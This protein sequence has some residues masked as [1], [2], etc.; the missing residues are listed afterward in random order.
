MA[1]KP[2]APVTATAPQVEEPVAT[3]LG[4]DD[5]TDLVG[6]GQPFPSTTDDAGGEV[7]G[8]PAGTDPATTPDP[9]PLDWGEGV[10]VPSRLQGKTAGQIVKEFTSMQE[11]YGRQGTELGEARNLLREAVQLTLGKT[12]PAQAE[13]PD[14]TGEEFEENSAAATQKMIDKSIA[15]LMDALVGTNKNVEQGQFT[16]AFPQYAEQV[17]TPEFAD[18][19]KASPY[20]SNLYQKADAHDFSAASELFTAYNE[21]TAAQ[22][23]G[24][25]SGTANA[26]TAAVR[27]AATESGGGKSAGKS[28]GKVY[29][30]AEI[31]RL[32]NSDR[33]RYNMLYPEFE[34]AQAEGRIK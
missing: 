12:D 33:E 18:W 10:E 4:G 26:K 17:R 21:H 8:D 11:S 31:M 28:S 23:G 22:T 34:K 6:D 13:A 27:A 14:P 7:T 20:R 5:P 3:F 15:P 32:Y 16:A 2:Q 25:N 1:T 29:L 19:V 9:D 30:A 24:D